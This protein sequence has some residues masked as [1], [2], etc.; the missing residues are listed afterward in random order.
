MTK[1]WN[2]KANSSVTSNLIFN[3]CTLVHNYKLFPFPRYTDKLFRDIESAFVRTIEQNM[4]SVC[5][6][7]VQTCVNYLYYA[8][9]VM[10]LHIHIHTHVLTGHGIIYDLWFIPV[11]NIAHV[12]IS[13]NNTQL[14]RKQRQDIIEHGMVYNTCIHKLVFKERVSGNRERMF[15]FWWCS[16]IS[17]WDVNQNLQVLW[18]SHQII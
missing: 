12:F 7:Q 15:T 5:I 17:L 4:R 2:V 1:L 9:A 16:E 18:C 14:A 11:N 6:W 3:L 13:I 10:F 8:A